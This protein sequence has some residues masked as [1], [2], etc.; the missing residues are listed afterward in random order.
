MSVPVNSPD[1]VRKG[2][3]QMKGK[4]KYYVVEVNE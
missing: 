1:D 2:I 4:G 3:E